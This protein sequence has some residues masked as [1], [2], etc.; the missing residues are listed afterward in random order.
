[1]FI[2][3]FFIPGKTLLT[4][5][6]NSF[7]YW[8]NHSFWYFFCLKFLI[9]TNKFKE[10]RYKTRSFNFLF[11]VFKVEFKFR[12]SK[13]NRDSLRENCFFRFSCFFCLMQNQP[14]LQ[15]LYFFSIHFILLIINFFIINI[16]SLIFL[17]L[18]PHLFF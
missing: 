5:L 3:I 2:I 9:F 6:I 7:N 12:F 16:L 18:I 1:M 11:F 10:I 13:E 8:L 14:Y 15:L 17:H 4:V